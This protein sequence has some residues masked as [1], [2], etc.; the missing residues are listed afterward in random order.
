MLPRSLFR[1]GGPYETAQPQTAPKL[2]VRFRF[3][4]NQSP[5]RG[6]DGVMDVL[7]AG[8]C[9]CGKVRYECTARREEVQMFRC[10]CRDCQRVS[11]GPH[12]PVIVA[13]KA[14]FRVVQ[15]EIRHH[16]TTSEAMGRHVRGYCADCGSRL[17]GGEGDPDPGNGIIGVT[18]TSLDDPS[19]FK[20]TVDMWVVDAQPWDSSLREPTAKFD[21]YPPS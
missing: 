7:F 6:V 4:R 18:A 15:G 16:Q 11:G 1:P 13:P 2:P 8:G 14:K 19:W 17:T 3:R 9:Y 21:R 20:P 10:H 12:V 5:D